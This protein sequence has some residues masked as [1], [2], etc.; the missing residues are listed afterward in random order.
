MP[1][2]ISESTLIGDILH[3]WTI[4]EYERHERT[5]RW[6]ISVITL[7][8]ILV[9]YGIFSDNFLFSLILILFAII[10][11]LQAH[12]PPMQVPFAVTELGV[13]VGS[14]FYKYS[15]LKSFYIIYSP[16]TV[17]TLFFQ[18]TAL[19]QPSLR[20]PLL[21]KNPV[22]IRKTLREYLD[23]DLDQEEEPYSDQMVRQWKL[24]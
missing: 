20:I 10:L 8:F 16:P 5:T 19:L 13:I 6:F 9:L 11:Y 12:Q 17:K 15:E 18:T 22:K 3:E 24:H 23:E 1:S 7:G 2:K 14:R 21:D 4:E